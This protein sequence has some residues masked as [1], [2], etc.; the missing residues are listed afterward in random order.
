MRLR[1][2]PAD[3]RDDLLDHLRASGCLAFK[4]GTNEIEVHLLNSVS[5]RHD[6][7]A[8]TGYVES[9]VEAHPQAR[10]DFVTR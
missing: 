2:G 9:W 6:R 5:E 1:L 10:A 7:Q 3:L 4:Q 8:L